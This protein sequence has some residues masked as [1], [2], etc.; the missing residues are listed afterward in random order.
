MTVAAGE[1]IGIVG[2]TGA[3]KTSIMTGKRVLV[4]V[5]ASLT[6]FQPSIV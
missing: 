5:M 6:S 1:K 4:F 3:G 2:R